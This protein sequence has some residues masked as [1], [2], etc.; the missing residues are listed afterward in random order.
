MK[1]MTSVEIV[2]T[3]DKFKTIREGNMHP[4]IGKVLGVIRNK[5]DEITKVYLD[6]VIHR[7]NDDFGKWEASGAISTVLTHKVLN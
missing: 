7:K 5:Y 1:E 3:E 2:L 6:R 4:I